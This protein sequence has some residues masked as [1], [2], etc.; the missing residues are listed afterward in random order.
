LLVD[1]R[2]A[3][4]LVNATT[5]FNTFESILG[6][7]STLTTGCV[8]IDAYMPFNDVIVQLYRSATRLVRDHRR[9]CSWVHVECRIDAQPAVFCK[10]EYVSGFSLLTSAQLKPIG[11]CSNIPARNMY[12][13]SNENATFPYTNHTVITSVTSASNSS[14]SASQSGSN[15]AGGRVSVSWLVAGLVA[16]V[17]VVMNS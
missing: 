10:W 8:R 11:T 4:G 7:A 6:N 9:S 16:G 12:A 1:W 2:V 13:E 14:Q 17:C 15:G 5:S 3:G